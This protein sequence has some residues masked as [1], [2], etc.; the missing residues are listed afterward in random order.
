MGDV[1]DLGATTINVKTSTAV[2]VILLPGSS[3]LALSSVMADDP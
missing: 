2:R 3:L 1:R